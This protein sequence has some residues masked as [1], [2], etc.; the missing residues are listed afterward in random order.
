MRIFG[1]SELIVPH[2]YIQ[3][4][5]GYIHGGKHQAVRARHRHCQAARLRG[6]IVDEFTRQ[7]L[8]P[9]FLY[10]AMQ[11][12]DFNPFA[13]GPPTRFGLAKGMWQFI[14]GTGKDYGLNIGPLKAVKDYDAS[15]DRMKWTR[16]RW[17]PPSTSRPSTRPTRR[18]QGCS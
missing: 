7:N 5:Q 4:V 12:S 17:P 15:D 6:R 14:P 16:R 9:Q 2:E 1:E 8:P 11:E 10:L 3:V 18:H 13:V